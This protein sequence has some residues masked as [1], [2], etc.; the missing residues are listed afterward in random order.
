MTGRAVERLVPARRPRRRVASG[1][2]LANV[3][4]DLD[5]HTAGDRIPAP[6]DEDLADEI[7][8]DVERRPGVETSRELPLP[9][10]A[11]AINAECGVLNAS[12]PDF[13]CCMGAFVHVGFRPAPFGGLA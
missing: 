2:R 8:G 12:P 11:L 9:D 10:H 1:V 6:M 5:D 13:H 7:A 3:G 4:F